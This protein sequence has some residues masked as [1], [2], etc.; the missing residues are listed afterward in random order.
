MKKYEAEIVM[1]GDMA[2][3]AK[4][5]G[6]DQTQL[7]AERFKIEHN[8]VFDPKEFLSKTYFDYFEED[9]AHDSH[10]KICYKGGLITQSTYE[11]L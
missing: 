2:R 6:L 3:D 8:L 1:T 7:A 10:F 11:S 4:R 9:C 5:R